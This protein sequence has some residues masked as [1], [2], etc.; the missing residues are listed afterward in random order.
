MLTIENFIPAAAGLIAGQICG[1]LLGRRGKKEMGKQLNR[2]STQIDELTSVVKGLVIQL[3]DRKEKEA[4]PTTVEKAQEI[5]KTA[6]EEITRHL[7]SLPSSSQ[8]NIVGSAVVMPLAGRVFPTGTLT[9]FPRDRE[10]ESV[11]NMWITR[12]TPMEGG[13]YWVTCNWNGKV[14]IEA[15]V[16]E[17]RQNCEAWDLLLNHQPDQEFAVLSGG[18]A[19]P[20]KNVQQLNCVRTY[21]I[22]HFG[23]REEEKKDEAT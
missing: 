14:D 12:V 20:L 15:Q 5:R 23:W 1:W 11:P 8:L 9:I 10:R 16:R 3:A 17:A 19:N 13:G 18:S 4:K 7:G 22:D 2:Q 21:L 6:A